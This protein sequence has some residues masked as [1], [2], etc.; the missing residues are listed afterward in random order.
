MTSWGA[1]VALLSALA[2]LAWWAHRRSIAREVRYSQML[3]AEVRRRTLELEQA[4]LTD[5]LT[6]L[7][8][9]RSLTRAMPGLLN[10]AQRGR[11]ALLIVDLDNLKPINDEFGHEGGDRVLVAV[12]ALLRETLRAEDR[13]ARWGGDEFVVVRMDATL[14]ETAALAE[15]IRAGVAGRRFPLADGGVA[16]ATC[17]IGFALYPFAERAAGAQSWAQ[18]LH[19]ADVAL[20]RAKAQRN[21][22]YGWSG[23]PAAAAAPELAAIPASQLDPGGE[24]HYVDSLSSLE[25]STLV[26]PMSQRVRARMLQS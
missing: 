9:R 1:A 5:A 20:Y 26:L 23:R 13:V 24:A 4:S 10:E 6:G 19:L 16:H 25:E 21:A 22:W 2:L 14:E 12:G 11:V 17:S 3:E 8:N 7:G 15:R 18:V